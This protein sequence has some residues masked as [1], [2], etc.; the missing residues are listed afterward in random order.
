M[1]ALLPGGSLTLKVLRL[2]LCLPPLRQR[3][4]CDQHY[5]SILMVAGPVTE[6]SHTLF[7]LFPMTDREAEAWDSLGGGVF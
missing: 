5:C 2:R 7:L 4:N 3:H 6:N 1:N